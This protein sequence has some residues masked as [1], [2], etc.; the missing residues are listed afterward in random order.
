MS[1]P[2]LLICHRELSMGPQMWDERGNGA[3]GTGAIGILVTCNE[4]HTCL[5]ELLELCLTHL[6]SDLGGNAVVHV[7]W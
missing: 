6:T 2:L 4:V 7:P 1:F 5:E 3:V